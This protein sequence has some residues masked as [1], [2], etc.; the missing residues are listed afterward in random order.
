[1]FT[2]IVKDLGHVIDR[3]QEEGGDVKFKIGTSFDLSGTEIGASISCSGCCLTVIEKSDNW[4]AVSA[5]QETLD[6][7]TLRSWQQGARVNLEKSL[8]MG[9]ELGGHMVTGHV[10]TVTR[11]LSITPEGDS[12]R[13]KIEIPDEYEVFIA[14]KGSVALD[15][16]SLTVNEVEGNVFGVNIIPHTWA[17]TTLGLK[18]PGDLLNFEVDMLARYVARYADRIV[19]VSN[20]S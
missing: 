2:G 1:M 13:L 14:S 5:S 8:K 6:K 9:D 11:L 3:Q 15:G 19:V 4:F 20:G 17:V 10:D 18:Q 12:F 16:I 7:T